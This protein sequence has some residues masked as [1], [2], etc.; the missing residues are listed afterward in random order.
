MPS[1]EDLPWYAL[2]IKTRQEKDVER[3]L[4]GRGYITFLPTYESIRSWSDRK[5]KISLPLFPGYLFCR[6]DVNHRLPVLQTPG[7][8]RITG[9]GQAFTPVEPSEI[10]SIERAIRL[11]VR[12]EPCPFLKVGRKVRI[13]E[14]SLRGME[15]ILLEVRKQFRLVVSVQLLQRSVALE[16]DT[17]AVE[18]AENTNAATG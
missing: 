7:V 5:R 10:E 13:V 1:A 8:F 9:T 11:K 3:L 12:C 15:G 18:T 4:Q 6:L 14:G 16:L 2:Q 17:A